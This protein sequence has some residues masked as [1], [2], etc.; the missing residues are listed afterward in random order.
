MMKLM[1]LW[2]LIVC[3]F[4]SLTALSQKK[5]DITGNWKV[6]RVLLP[7]ELKGDK[8]GIQK[9]EKIMLQT[10]FHF[11]SDGS[12]TVNSPEK[13][14]QFK[15]CKWTFNNKEKSIS[16]NGE[17]NGEKGLLMIIIVSLKNNKWYFELVETTVTLEVQRTG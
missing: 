5:E 10:S 13:E 8:Q 14:M 17:V 12:C 16:I 11:N 7:A 6:I 15:K 2:L 1:K 3:S 4:I 9:M